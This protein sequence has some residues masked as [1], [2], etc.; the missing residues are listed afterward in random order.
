MS[1]TKPATER[2]K[3][4]AEVDTINKRRTKR[5]EADQ[6]DL[7]RLNKIERQIYRLGIVELLNV[8]N[9]ARLRHRRQSGDRLAIHNDTPGTVTEVR[10]TRCTVSFNGDVWHLP[11]ESVMA[12]AA[13]QG[14]QLGIALIEW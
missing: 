6:S 3:L 13:M 5:R 14:E 1:R 7:Q 10:R 8:E 12:A 9:G 4:E 11:I 2:E